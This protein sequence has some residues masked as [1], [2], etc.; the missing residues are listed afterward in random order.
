[1]SECECDVSPEGRTLRCT[2]CRSAHERNKLRLVAQ[3]AMSFA[4]DMQ[5]Q[6]RWARSVS[7][8]LSSELAESEQAAY[9][10]FDSC[11]NAL[12]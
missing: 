2:R 5:Q 8:E 9:A 10:L 1:M 6:L 3:E 7:D 12:K 11:W 4:A